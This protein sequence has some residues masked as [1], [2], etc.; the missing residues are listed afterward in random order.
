LKGRLGR[1]EISIEVSEPVKL[2]EFLEGTQSQD[3]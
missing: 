2:K 3:T 1:D